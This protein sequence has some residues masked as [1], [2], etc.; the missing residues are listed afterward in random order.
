MK[1]SLELSNF[2]VV[3]GSVIDDILADSKEHVLNIVRETY[4]LHHQGHTVNPNSYFLRFPNKP[5]D[6]VI[7]LPVYV[8]G[9]VNRIG[10]KWVSSFPDNLLS[11]LSRASAVLIINDSETGYPVACLEGAQISAAR[12]AA[13]AA[14]AAKLLAR[15]T[16]MGRLAFVGTGVIARSILEYLDE[17]SFP[18]SEVTCFDLAADRARAFMAQV[19]AVTDAPVYQADLIDEAIECDTVVFTTTAAEPYVGADTKLRPGQLILNISLRDLAPELLL[20]SDNVVD[21][22]DHCLRAGTSPHLAE[23]L[24]GTREFVTGTLGDV[25]SN[26]VTLA[27][28]RPV[29]FSPFGL[30]S[31]DLAV[32]S[33]V[34]AEA[35]R[36][37][38]ALPIPG[39]FGK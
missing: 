39:F 18:V 11:G 6:R 30:G 33:Y 21:D 24:S 36:R 28:E 17:A 22:V 14:L 19:A 13:S 1:G 27:P 4:L 25:L 31:L 26:D 2:H 23:Q 8:N 12:T 9:S 38:T 34:L 15:D 7:A 5:R 20:N 37:G 10:I 32:G 3:P 16:Q 35:C 29:I